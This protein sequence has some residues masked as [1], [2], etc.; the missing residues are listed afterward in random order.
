MDGAVM[1]DPPVGAE[2]E[3]ELQSSEDFEALFRRLKS[4]CR[5]DI[6]RQRDWRREAREDFAFVAS[7][8]WSEEDKQVLREQLRPIITMNR[9]EPVVNSISGQEVSNRQEVRYIPR[10]EG[11]V[12]VNEILTGAAQWFR[13]EC[14][15][16]D[17][18]SDAFRD[19]VICGMGWTETRLDYED[20]PDGMP[21]IDRIDPLQMVWDS[22]A[23]KKNLADAKRVFHVRRDVPIEE[24]RQLIQGDEFEDEDYDA[25]WVDIDDAKLDEH[26]N[27]GRYYEDEGAEADREDEKAEK[28]VTLVRA[29]W[30]ERV[31]AFRIADP[32]AP[33]RLKTVS[34][35]ELDDLNAKMSMLGAQ[36]LR[37]VQVTRKVYRQAYLGKVL[38]EVGDAPCPEHFSFQCITGARDRNKNQF[39]GVVRSL[40][41]PQRWA[42]KW[43]SQLQHIMN[44]SS[45]GGIMAERGVFDDDGDAEKSW[46]KQDVITWVKSG[47]LSAGKIEPKPSAQFPA[48][49]YQLTEL[50][51][52]SIRDVSG[53]SVEMLGLREANQAASLEAQRRQ[54][55]MIILQPLF[56]GLRRYRKMQ[57][58]ML[59]YLIQ[60]YLSDG[61]L[62]RI[63]SDQDAKYIRLMR[64]PD[65]AVY[66]V[67]VDE[68]PT[69]PNQ[70]EATWAMLQ[71][72]L[73]AIGKMIPPDV[74][75]ALLKY[76][77]LPSS[78]Q[79]DIITAMQG[80]QQQQQADPEMLKVQAEIKAGAERTAAEIENSRKKTD[81]DIENKRRSAMADAQIKALSAGSPGA[82]GSPQP[83]TGAVLAPL[84]VQ[85]TQALQALSAPKELVF[86]EAGE[87][88]GVRPVGA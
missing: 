60:N 74:W 32:L 86:N 58:R 2:A 62:I 15:A 5:M 40:K 56:D 65:V 13:D 82:D 41:D 80:S 53:V 59:L 19:T 8:Q 78:V 6:E 35:E 70:K 71:Q 76:S 47:K 18:E 30:V 49:F 24:A 29:Q 83:D 26:H 46:A 37:S 79:Q 10:E 39:Y 55:A 28:T 23:K 33:G 1:S 31:P 72:L 7:D 20:D 50:A 22:S 69:S 81:A 54:S 45:K 61:R 27:D 11:D 85:L 67:V 88:V 4:Q 34:R 43:L 87:P 84:F 36:P 25:K 51:I 17:E 3:R 57:G 9:I 21:F 12:K 16:E 77:P 68:S 64:D 75:I 66:D 63:G 38:L 42:N 44:S 14:D 73:P 48:G 52:S